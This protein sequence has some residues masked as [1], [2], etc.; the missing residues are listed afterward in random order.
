MLDTRATRGADRSGHH[1]AVVI[2]MSRASNA[3]LAG[4]T[5]LFYIAVAFPDMLLFGRATAGKNTAEK[6]ASIAQ[7]ASDLH[8]AVVLTMLSGLSAL[9]LGVTLY[10]ITRDE[11]QDLAMLAMACRIGE[12]ILGVVG[13]PATLGLLWLA[14][15]P[16]N[17]DS[18]EVQTL[19]SFV[20]KRTPLAGA[21]FFSVGSTIFCWLLLRGRIVPT[22]L[23]W[24]G[25]LGSTLLVVTIPMQLAAVI[26]SPFTELVWAPMA[27]FEISV[28]FWLIFKGAAMPA[29]TR[30][31]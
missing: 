15:R 3:R 29:P 24:I 30:A 10:A 11:D 7:H 18:L 2:S 5:F 9:V 8:L 28:A 17:V 6:L 1:D 13:I 27:V 14:S 12:G 19:A 4:A 23:S 21:W 22:W 31:A 16:G 26:G 25:V 20:L